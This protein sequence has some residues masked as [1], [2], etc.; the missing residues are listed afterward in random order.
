MSLS[1]GSV[2]RLSVLSTLLI[3]CAGLLVPSAFA[4]GV[5]LAVYGYVTVNG[6]PMAGV[7][8]S[9]NDTITSTNSTGFYEISPSV[10]TGSDVTVTAVY[11]GHSASGT[12][13]Q[14]DQGFV[15]LNLSIMAPGSSPSTGPSGQGTGGSSGSSGGSGSSGSSGTVTATVMPSPVPTANSKTTV[16]S[17]T[18][19]PVPVTPTPT[20]A[21]SGTSTPKPTPGIM[22]TFIPAMLVLC[23]AALRKRS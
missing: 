8:I 6:A 13:T 2:F 22:F 15:E 19:T 3:I 17:S 14:N 16:I 11:Q 12:I 10:V 7:M 18:H 20:I 4:S 23:L 9:A 21:P 5:P 1:K